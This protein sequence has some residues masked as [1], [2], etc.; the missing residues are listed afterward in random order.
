MKNE[1]IGNNKKIIKTKFTSIDYFKYYNNWDDTCRDGDTV[2]SEDMF[3]KKYNDNII[4]IKK[5]KNRLF[6]KHLNN[7]CEL[8]NF[9]EQ[10]KEFLFIF[11]L[12][13]SII[14]FLILSFYCY[15]YYEKKSEF[16]NTKNILSSSML[17]LKSNFIVNVNYYY[18]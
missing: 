18:D 7:K 12:I 3:S 6:N 1:K 4:V 11:A 5:Y 9:K 17:L 2:S 13:F 16:L 10:F 14:S 8:E 15:L